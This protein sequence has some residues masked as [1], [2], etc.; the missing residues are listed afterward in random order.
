MYATAVVRL[1]GGAILAQAGSPVGLVAAVGG[2]IIALLAWQLWRANR[3]YSLDLSEQ[4]EQVA[5][6]QEKARRALEEKEAVT[7]ESQAKGE[8][9]ATLSHEIRAHLNGVIGSA[10]LLLE[11]SLKQQQRE[12]V[13]TLRF[14][15]ESLH[16]SLNDVLEYSS[17]ES[18]Q[19]QIAQASFDL[20]QPLIEIMEQFSPQ[21]ALRG[22]ELVLL[23][24]PDV[25]T[26]VIGDAERLHQILLN[27]VANAVKFTDHGRIVLRVELPPGSMAPF[28]PGATWLH[29]SVS[30]TG[31]GIPAEMLGT[32]FNRFVPA[33]SSPRKF[34]GSG[35]ELAISKRLVELLG[36]KIEARSLPDSGSEFLTALP[37][38]ADTTPAPLRVVPPAG[39]HVVVLDDLGAARIAASALFT[40]MGIDHDV[41]DSQTKAAGLLRDALDAGAQDLVL[42]LDESIARER[43]ADLAKLV[44]PGSALDATRI[45][46]MALDP[47]TAS[48]EVFEFRIAAMVR[49][50]L[51]RADVVLTALTQEPGEGATVVTASAPPFGFAGDVA[52]TARLGPKVLVVDDD[53]ISRSVT[54]QLLERLGCVVE[55]VVSGAEAIER[56]RRGGL[57]LIYMDCQMPE[58]DG[59]A[60]TERIRA[61]PGLTPPPIVALTA[62]TGVED[63]KRCF[64]VGMCDFV[65]KPVRKAEL[66][67]TLKSWIRPELFTA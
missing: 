52:A 11:N 57:D 50:P 62:N 33:D 5:Q 58:L 10:D 13:T 30:D 16:Q 31:R 14:S 54:S 36:G 46:L 18:G 63:R 20:R 19:I 12:L 37:L 39:L 45:V 15:A 41:T 44:A 67:R 4:A 9:L 38:M 53:E 65:G 6:E 60:T 28:K 27:L 34:G 29:F 1:P 7:R 56:V 35:L 48:H 21:A 26:R 43:T 47:E 23:V 42:L 61:L 49:K 40:R 8:M 55:K 66:T 17:I 64:A 3:N 51:M 32:I 25:P 59:Y 24:A 2:V 22:L